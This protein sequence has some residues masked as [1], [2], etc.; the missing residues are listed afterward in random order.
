MKLTIDAICL[1]SKITDKMQIDK[2]FIKEMFDYSKKARETYKDKSEEEQKELADYLQ[3]EIGV[4][5]VLKL[6]TK[7][8][9]VKDELIK[10]ISVY[11]DISEEEAQKVDIVEFVKEAI[12]DEGLTSFLKRQVI[13]K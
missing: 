1:I 8:Y 6:G 5:V 12:S 3:K 13:S 9:E 4:Q 2:D 10:F 7:L 11:K